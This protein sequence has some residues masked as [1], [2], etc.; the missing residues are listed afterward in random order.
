MTKIYE[1]DEALKHIKVTE[2]IQ[3]E[4]YYN[5]SRLARDIDL[6]YGRAEKA[7]KNYNEIVDVLTEI[8][9]S[10]AKNHLDV[11]IPKKIQIIEV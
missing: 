4:S 2:D 9:A 3:K 7:I 5:N 11:C 8:N 6:W 1:W 10:A